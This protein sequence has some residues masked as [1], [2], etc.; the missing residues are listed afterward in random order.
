[1]RRIRQI[2]DSKFGQWLLSAVA[3]LYVRLVYRCNR[4]ERVGYDIADRLLADHRRAIICFWHGRLLMMP[5]AVRGDRPFH[6][7]VSDH[8]DGKLIA[9]TVRRF[10][11]GVIT[12]SSSRQ[13][14]QAVYRV[15][16]ICRTYGL[17]CLTPDG[18]RGPRMHAAPG[19]VIAAE[20]AEAVL[21]PVSFSTS[22][23]RIIASWDRFLLPLPFGRGVFVV[24][25]E[26]E[27]P[28]GLDAAGREIL[29]LRLEKALNDVTR[30]ADGRAGHDPSQSAR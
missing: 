15:A 29:R 30:E 14:V 13:P 1:M 16:E 5:Y 28:P 10:G 23:R 25:P 6:I 8:R 22:R 18:P 17:P 24:G 11:I 26:I 19:P 2:A 3:A 12:G 27:V 20:M 7:L 9:R 4:W 21:V